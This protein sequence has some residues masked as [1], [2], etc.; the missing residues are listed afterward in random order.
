MQ[1]IVTDEASFVTFSK[2]KYP[3]TQNPFHG[4]YQNFG[5]GLGKKKRRHSGVSLS[6]K[7]EYIKKKKARKNQ[8]RRQT[9][10]KEE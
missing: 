5:L 7:A 2:L 9:T 1:K 8:T 3:P 4:T 10:K 6:L